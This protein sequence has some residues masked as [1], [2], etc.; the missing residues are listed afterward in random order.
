M[1]VLRPWIPKMRDGLLS[2]LSSAD[3]VALER[4][5][6]AT[7]TALEAILFYAPGTPQPR[8]RFEWIAGQLTLLPH[9]PAAAV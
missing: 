2:R 4:I 6:G 8:Y 7:A 3:P 1:R 5:M 9:E